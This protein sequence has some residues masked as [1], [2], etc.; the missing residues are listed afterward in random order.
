MPMLLQRWSDR[1]TLK[2]EKIQIREWPSNFYKNFFQIS[3]TFSML[4]KIA[5]YAFSS[6]IFLSLWM[7]GNE[8]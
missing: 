8:K 6:T 5:C 2:L 3:N 7:M 4:V 1:Q